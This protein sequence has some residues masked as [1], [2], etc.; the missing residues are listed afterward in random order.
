MYW[1]NAYY[2]IQINEFRNIQ[3]GTNAIPDDITNHVYKMDG[4]LYN[5]SES[6][7]GWW[8]TYQLYLDNRFSP[9]IRNKKLAG[10]QYGILP[11]FKKVT[12]DFL[13]VANNNLFTSFP[14]L[15]PDP[16]PASTDWQDPIRQSNGTSLGIFTSDGITNQQFFQRINLNFQN[17]SG[18]AGMV[19]ITWIMAA[20]KSTNTTAPFDP[21]GGFGQG[22]PG[23]E[24]TLFLYENLSAANGLQQNRMDG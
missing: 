24:F 13:N 15:S 9:S 7:Q 16:V 4:G 21:L 20:R 19:D 2:F 22:G 23:N 17:N 18:V 12:I 10:G 14:L 11:A 1:R 8:G 3:N 6:V 5:V